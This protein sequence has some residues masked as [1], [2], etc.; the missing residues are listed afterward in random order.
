MG[1]GV[2]GGIPCFIHPSKWEDTAAF[3]PVRGGGNLVKEWKE[4][5]SLNHTPAD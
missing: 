5:A 3:M 1:A 4:G 2:Q